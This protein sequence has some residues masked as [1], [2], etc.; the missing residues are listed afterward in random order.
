MGHDGIDLF[1]LGGDVSIGGQ[2]K[3]TALGA[4][5]DPRRIRRSRI[6]EMEREAL[7]PIAGTQERIGEPRGRIQAALDEEDEIR[8]RGRR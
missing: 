4:E 6:G 3:P 2:S 7:E 8:P 1:R 5:S